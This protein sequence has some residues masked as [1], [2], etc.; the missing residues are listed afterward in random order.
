MK[1]EISDINDLVSFLTASAMKP[2]LKDEIWQCYG[3][4]KRP[5]HGNIWNK[6]FPKMFALENFISKE[7]LTMGLIDVLSGVKKSAETIDT[8]LLISVGIIDRFLSATKHIFSINS[9]MENLFSVYASILR[10][11]KSKIYEPIILKSKS[12][13]NK[14]D[15]AKFMVGSAKLF[16]IEHADDFLLK[17]NYIKGIIEKSAKENK[18]KISMPDEIYK[19]YVPLIE[20]KILNNGIQ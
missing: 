1:T 7:I 18:L 8:K 2:L 5:K 9:F 4:N 6:I 14:K 13:L 16:A 11:E 20:A 17:S 3:Y 10:S 19:K 15:F 12:I